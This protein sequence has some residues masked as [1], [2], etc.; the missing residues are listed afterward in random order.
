[1]N[2][3]LVCLKELLKRNKDWKYFLNQAGTA[4]P[5]KSIRKISEAVAGLADRDSVFSM[6]VSKKILNFSVKPSGC[7]LVFSFQQES[8]K[9]SSSSTSDQ[10][11]YRVKGRLLVFAKKMLSTFGLFQR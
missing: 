7:Q 2:A 6:I 4:L 11:L 5:T 3:D 10:R 8:L 9:G 1:M